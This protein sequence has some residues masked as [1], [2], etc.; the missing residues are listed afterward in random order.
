M[1]D[2]GC[3]VYGFDRIPDICIGEK[4]AGGSKRITVWLFMGSF[5]F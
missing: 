4:M 3:R 1:A 5:V 2:S